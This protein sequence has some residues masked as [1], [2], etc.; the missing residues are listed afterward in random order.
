MGSI[1][2]N[3]FENYK[4]TFEASSKG[5]FLSKLKG[6]GLDSLGGLDSFMGKDIINA[7]KLLKA[8]K[9]FNLESIFS[10]L[11]GFFQ[12]LGKTA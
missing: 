11:G 8:F 9:G 10:N 4:N 12:N 5:G 3:S 6:F 2:T 1:T 7:N